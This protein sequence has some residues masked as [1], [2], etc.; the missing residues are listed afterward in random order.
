MKISKEKT[1]QLSEVIHHEIINVRI[2]LKL[3][4]YEDYILS[5]IENSMWDKIK[6]VLNIEKEQK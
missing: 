2:K 3:P 5:K 1:D 4:H 6:N